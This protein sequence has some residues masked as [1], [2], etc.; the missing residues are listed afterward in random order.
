MVKKGKADTKRSGAVS[1]KQPASGPASA[2][3]KSRP[4]RPQSLKS[5]S[6]RQKSADAKSRSVRQKLVPPPPGPLTSWEAQSA[7]FDKHDFV[8]LEK[9]GH[10]SELTAADRKFLDQVRTSAWLQRKRE[11]VNL[12]LNP[13]QFKRLEAV[14]R[15]RHLAP[16]TLARAWLLERLDQELPE[17]P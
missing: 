14:A 8:S 5:R 13:Q 6:A 16:S 4:V 9:A 17:R 3:G 1:K 12:T 10:L 11:Q 7:Y 15:R 2:S